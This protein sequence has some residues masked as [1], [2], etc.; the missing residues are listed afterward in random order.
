MIAVFN[1]SSLPVIL[2]DSR[3]MKLWTVTLVTCILTGIVA[4]AKAANPM[5]TGLLSESES[6]AARTLRVSN[7]YPFVIREPVRFVLPPDLM[8][9]GN[10]GEILGVSHSVS[11][12][13]VEA[14]YLPI[15]VESGEGGSPAAAWIDVQ[16]RPGESRTYSFQQIGGNSAEAQAG[17]VEESF[18]SGLPARFSWQDKRRTDLF[19]VA[20]YTAA[21]GDATARESQKALTVQFH[22]VREEHGPVKSIFLYRG[23][24][25]SGEGESPAFRMEIRYD[26]YSSGVT[27]VEI[28]IASDEAQNGGSGGRPCLAVAKRLPAS[29]GN[30]AAAGANGEIRQLSP[31]QADAVVTNIDW[32]AWGNFTQDG[33]GN[34]AVLALPALQPACADDSGRGASFRSA[35]AGETARKDRDSWI[36]LS[37]ISPLA[38]H[39]L[40]Y[41]VLPLASRSIEQADEAARAFTGYLGRQAGS[42]DDEFHV[43]FGASATSFG[44]RYN[45]KGL[46]GDDWWTAETEIVRDLRIA[47][48]IG[49]DWI[50]LP[51][52]TFQ[53]ARASDAA[54]LLSRAARET[55]LRYFVD[56]DA[57]SPGRMIAQ[58]LG[59]TAGLYG[60]PAGSEKLQDIAAA[61]RGAHP[62]ARFALVGAPETVALVAAL[63][64]AGIAIAAFA[65]EVP[66]E[67]HNQFGA[68]AAT[69]WASRN[70]I[71]PM[72]G[73]VP[74]SVDPRAGEEARALQYYEDFQQFLNRRGAPV[75]F[76]GELARNDAPAGEGGTLPLLR[77]DRTPRIIAHAF[78]ALAE[79]NKKNTPLGRRA[80]IEM[81]LLR[82]RPEETRDLPVTVRNLSTQPLE[83]WTQAH[84][85]AGVTVTSTETRRNF[86]LRPH[87]FQTVTLSIEAADDLRSGFYHLFGEIRAGGEESDHVQFGWTY[88]S[89]RAPPKLDLTSPAAENVRYVD[90]LS[91]LGRLNL[92]NLRHTVFGRS[93]SARELEWAGRLQETLRRAT[94]ADIRLWAHDELSEQESRRSLLLV[95]NQESNP[96]IADLASRLPANPLELRPGEGTVMAITHPEN[97][98]RFIVIISGRDADGV[99]SAAAD[100]AKRY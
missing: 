87:Q 84:P 76:Q 68:P 50:R 97:P 89:H 70:G 94:G 34:Q 58:G 95:G 49:I 59:G 9:S 61:I 77:L 57:E 14:H 10:A 45:P 15:Q 46:Y 60:L 35:F 19:D 6:I 73:N 96:A 64:E 38:K 29:D 18:A 65:L 33:D 80:S 21:D 37:E 52:S 11:G 27:D 72:V 67:I 81:P 17:S 39:G 83:I 98:R 24:T 4:T 53:V 92:S 86:T 82:I 54:A 26:F 90:G 12:G 1:L 62:E 31:D 79:Q 23:E 41:R 55:R 2:P 51:A 32:L 56:L 100:F 75:V 20:F 85:P 30:A 63:E 28:A 47:H 13:A 74:L 88:L 91:N 66:D 8:A 25:R 69:G 99:A 40:R 71:V 42:S 93:A 78:H 22:Q 5:E 3:A 36:L 7:N 16:L 48:A 43:S 44:T